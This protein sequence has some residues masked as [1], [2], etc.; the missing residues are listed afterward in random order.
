MDPLFREKFLL[1]IYCSPDLPHSSEAHTFE[2]VCPV[3]LAPTCIPLSKS[4]TVD[5]LA[6]HQRVPNASQNPTQ[7]LALE[8][9]KSPVEVSLAD[10]G[11][12][13]QYAANLDSSPSVSSI[14]HALIASS[15]AAEVGLRTSS[16]HFY[17]PLLSHLLFAQ[18]DKA[19][20]EYYRSLHQEL[21]SQ[22]VIRC[23]GAETSS[24]WGYIHILRHRR[25]RW[26]LN[27]LEQPSPI[28][29][30]VGDDEI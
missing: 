6:K 26:G 18:D 19:T 12:L 28:K 21:L 23:V 1:D 11:L 30:N 9:S 4:S 20:F 25:M 27:C 16:P 10:L 3:L 13:F 17:L 22:Y 29:G 15:K 8:P 24:P 14:C 5:H 2:T 7:F